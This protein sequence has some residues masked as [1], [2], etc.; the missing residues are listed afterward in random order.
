LIFDSLI[1]TFVDFASKKY[2]LKPSA[3]KL[4]E[5]SNWLVAL[6]LRPGVVLVALE[7][8]I[9]FKKRR[10]TSIRFSLD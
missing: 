9:S 3:G 5:K 6:L 7:T 2:V 1:S 8:G 10:L 4:A